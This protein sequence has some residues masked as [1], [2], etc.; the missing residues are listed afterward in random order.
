MRSSRVWSSTASDRFLVLF[1]YSILA[2]YYSILAFYYSIL[3]FYYSILAFYNSI[4]DFY[5]SILD[6]HHSILDFYYSILDFYNSILD[7]YYSKLA[8]FN[9]I[10]DTV[11][12]EILHGKVLKCQYLLVPQRIPYVQYNA[13]WMAPGNSGFTVT[14]RKQ[15]SLFFKVSNINTVPFLVTYFA[16]RIYQRV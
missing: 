5:H 6:F 15:W 11:R 13:S 9:S 10:L 16:L 12:K 1:Y 4:L 2:F 8:F 14:L 3:A 7:F